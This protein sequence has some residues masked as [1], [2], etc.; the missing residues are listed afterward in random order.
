MPDSELLYL[1]GNAY[2]KLDDPKHYQR[3]VFDFTEAIKLENKKKEQPQVNLI[4]QL[5]YKR[6]FAYQ[7]L[8]ENYQALSDYS[9][10]VYFL[11]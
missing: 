9:K 6:A 10:T 4:M 7:M 2:L 5:H 8:G 1:R 11:L 3:A